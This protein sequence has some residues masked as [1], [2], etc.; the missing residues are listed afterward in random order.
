MPPAA[1][2]PPLDVVGYVAVALGPNRERDLDTAARI[3][4][5]WC[6][7]RGW[8]LA[9]VVHDITPAT[10]RLADRPG[11]AHV[12]DQI[13]DGRVA[14][15]VVARLGDVTR[16]VSELAK[17]LRWIDT[18]DAFMI[19]VDSELDTTTSAGELAANALVHIGEWER[20]RIATRTHPGLTAIRAP[21]APPRRPSATT[22][23]SAPAS[24]PCVPEACPCKPSATPSTP[25]GCPRSAAAPNGAPRASKPPPAT[26]A[27][28]SPAR[29]WDNNPA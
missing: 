25:R 21:G 7:S 26:N 9:R 27:P 28:T 10:G 5:A 14:G 18:A 23:S 15:L 17:L 3:I 16:S 8:H 20:D 13:A 6:E 11:L 22:P 2:A 12:L 19:A 29:R 4:G 1:P 24:T